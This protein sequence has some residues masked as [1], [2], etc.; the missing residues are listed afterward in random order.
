[1]L[2]SS[3]YGDC[4][5]AEA[6]WEALNYHP[7]TADSADGGDPEER[8]YMQQ[9]HLHPVHMVMIKMLLSDTQHPLRLQSAWPPAVACPA[10]THLLTCHV[11]LQAAATWLPILRRLAGFVIDEHLLVVTCGELSF[12]KALPSCLTRKPMQLHAHR[13]S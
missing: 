13:C 10:L 5:G 4:I 1:M 9:V 7:T 11:A 2:V 3:R 6:A 12:P 8:D